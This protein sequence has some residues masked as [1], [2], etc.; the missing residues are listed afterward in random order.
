MIKNDKQYRIA[1]TRP[2]PSGLWQ[3]GPHLDDYGQRQDA[4]GLR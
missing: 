4:E 2:R 3:A 1:V